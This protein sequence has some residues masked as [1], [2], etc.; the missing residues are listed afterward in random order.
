M[1][2]NFSFLLLPEICTLPLYCRPFYFLDQTN[3]EK[4]CNNSKLWSRPVQCL[5]SS[6]VSELMISCTSRNLH[7]TLVLY[8]TQFLAWDQPE[9]YALILK[10]GP[11]LYS[12][13]HHPVSLKLCTQLYTLFNSYKVQDPGHWPS[14]VGF[15]PYK[16]DFVGP[17]PWYTHRNS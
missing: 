17:K 4:I 6:H 3:L 16:S 9:K 2:Q 8:L 15:C 12:R 7:F 10:Y 14:L 5:T 11:V 1:I 13:L